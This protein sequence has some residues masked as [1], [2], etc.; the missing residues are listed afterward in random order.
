MR[1]DLLSVVLEDPRNLYTSRQAKRSRITESVLQ[2]CRGLPM[3]NTRQ[4]FIRDDFVLCMST[5]IFT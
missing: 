5:V 3:I 1:Y 4:W 2:I